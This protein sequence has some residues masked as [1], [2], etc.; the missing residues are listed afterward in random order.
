M[1]I[2]ESSTSGYQRIAHIKSLNVRPLDKT[3][4]HTTPKQCY[5]QYNILIEKPEY[6]IIPA[7]IKLEAHFKDQVQRYENLEPAYITVNSRLITATCRT[8]IRL[9]YDTPSALI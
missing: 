7:M 8:C 5:E 3:K 9:V 2:H 6:I 1:H 4:E